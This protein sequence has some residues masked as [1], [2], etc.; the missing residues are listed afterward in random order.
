MIQSMFFRTHN[1][2]KNESKL[3]WK[4]LNEWKTLE[5]NTLDFDIASGT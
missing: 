3:V 5:Y 2:D 4:W 1:H